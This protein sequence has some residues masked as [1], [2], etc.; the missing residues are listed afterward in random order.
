MG[1]LTALLG[2]IILLMLIP[3]A[4]LYLLVGWSMVF[5]LFCGWIYNIAMV[6]K[7]GASRQWFA[8]AVFALLSLI[9]A[10]MIGKIMAH[11]IN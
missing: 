7:F 1:A 8:V 2:Y 3:N 11:L 5:V 9:N 10:I 4:Y 6:Q